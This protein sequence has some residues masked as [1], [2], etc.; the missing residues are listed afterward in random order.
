MAHIKLFFP[1]LANTT[2]L[3]SFITPHSALLSLTLPEDQNQEYP[4]PSAEHFKAYAHKSRPFRRFAARVKSEA[5]LIKE[6][7]KSLKFAFEDDNDYESGIQKGND[8][9]HALQLE[10]ECD[11]SDVET[12][13]S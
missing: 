3:F 13:Q 4:E 7:V 5:F 8:F 1:G 2:S 12:V 11:L 6:E 9:I 10:E